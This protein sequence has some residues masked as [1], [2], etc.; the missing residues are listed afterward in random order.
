ML[1]YIVPIIMNDIRFFLYRLRIY[2]FKNESIIFYNEQLQLKD[3]NKLKI[4]E[5]ILQDYKKCI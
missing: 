1:C 5:I 3:E 4:M 2:G